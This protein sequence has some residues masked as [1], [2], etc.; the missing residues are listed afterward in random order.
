MLISHTATGILTSLTGVYPDRMGQ[1]VSNSF[2]LLHADGHEPHR[3]RRSPT[4][5]RRSSTR[6]GSPRPD[7]HARDDQRERQDRP[8]PVGAVHPCRLRRRRGRDREHVLEN[9]GDR[10]PDRSSAP[11]RPRQRGRGRRRTRDAGVRRLRRHRRPLRARRRRCARPPTT[12]G[13][14]CCP[15]SRAATPASTAL[16]GAKYVDPVIKPSGP[17]DRP[18]RQRHPGRERPRRL[19]RLRR[20]GGDGVAV[21]G[22]ADAGGRHPR[23][24]RLHLG[25]ARR[26]RHAGNIHFAY[27]PGEA[28][29]VQQLQ[30]YD[31]A[32]AEVLRPPRGRRHQQG[33]TLFVFTVDEGDHFVGDHADARPAA[34]ASTR[35]AR[36]TAS[37]RSTPTCAG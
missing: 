9:T 5:P 34:T 36:T 31:M 24:V 35:R 17:H 22:R 3:R 7:D 1:P 4:G 6:P 10:H 27:G 12:A 14:T 33:N 15:T 13:P 37:A 28:G 19:P 32:F 23:H 20:H 21:L 25:R 11:A 16:F 18:E 29:Y 2:R 26:P 30:D 8:G